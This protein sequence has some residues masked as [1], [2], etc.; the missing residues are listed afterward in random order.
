MSKN[1]EA[2]DVEEARRRW[3]KRRLDRLA[4]GEVKVLIG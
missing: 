1:D 4:R 3:E 2:D